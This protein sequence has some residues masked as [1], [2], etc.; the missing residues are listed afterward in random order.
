MAERITVTLYELISELD[1]W[2]DAVL[3]AHHGVTFSHF[4]FLNAIAQYQPVDI[5]GLAECLRVSKAAVSKRVPGF[6]QGGWVQTSADPAHARRVLLTLTDKSASLV[7]R[8][9]GELDAEFRSLFSDPRLAQE[10]IDVDRL[11]SQLN[12]LTELVTE[13]ERPS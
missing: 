2:A 12:R 3:R 1:G 5:T 11:N 9:G 10:R 7:Q 6:V 4:A 8:A 13:K